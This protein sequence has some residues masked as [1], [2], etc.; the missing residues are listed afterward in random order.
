M[1]PHGDHH[2][3]RQHQPR[4]PAHH[5]HLG[6]V[7]PPGPPAPP[8]RVLHHH[9]AHPQGPARVVQLQP[10]GHPPLVRSV[11]VDEADLEPGRV[12]Q[13][14][15]RR[16]LPLRQPVLE[17]FRGH[18]GRRPPVPAQ[19]AHGLPQ[20]RQ[21]R[22][23]VVGHAP[24]PVAPVRPRDGELVE[25]GDR[26]GAD[27]PVGGLAGARVGHHRSQLRG[28]LQEGG[29]H[30]AYGP[31]AFRA[32]VREHR[33]EAGEPGLDGDLVHQAGAGQ[34]ALGSRPRVVIHHHRQQPRVPLLRRAPAAQ[35]PRE[36]HPRLQGFQQPGRS[37]LQSGQAPQVR[38]ARARR[39]DPDRRQ[40]QTGP[41]H[42][43]SVSITP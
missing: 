21:R 23:Q 40:H 25:D 34:P 32:R 39:Q 18:P 1:P 11:P 14:H 4:A 41:P 31:H 27:V 35:K 37:Q 30:A 38:P 7:H 22:V 16:R 26:P 19:A 3:P 9:R 17:A 28:H 5:P 12:G 2:A 33:Q 15:L 24:G 6:H 20:P 36:R 42:R 10:T 13:A 29:P 43:Y 8:P